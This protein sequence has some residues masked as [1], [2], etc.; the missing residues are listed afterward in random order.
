MVR[1]RASEQNV[2]IALAFTDIVMIQT[3]PG[4]KDTENLMLVAWKGRPSIHAAFKECL[5]QLTRDS[6][7]RSPTNRHGVTVMELNKALKA[8]GLRSIR[9]KNRLMDGSWRSEVG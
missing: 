1:P 3:R 6:S 7:E 4:T 9:R 5:P 2:R 8:A